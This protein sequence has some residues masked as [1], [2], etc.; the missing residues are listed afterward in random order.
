MVYHTG[1]K[2][3]LAVLIFCLVSSCFVYV[4]SAQSTTVAA[5]ASPDKL[6]VGDTLTVTVKIRDAV[7]LYGVDVTLNWNSSVLKA[8]S[9]TNS[10]GVESNSNGVL[11]KSSAYPIDVEEDAINDGQYHLLATSQGQ[12]TPSFSGSGTIVTIIFNVTGSGSANLALDNVELSTRDSTGQISLVTPETNVSTVTAT[13]P[14]FPATALVL[15][16]AVAAAAIILIAAKKIGKPQLSI[17]KNA[18]QA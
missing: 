12:S 14:E 13:I 10:L 17:A 8:V 18:N 4:A 16:L 5:E 3:V 1:G 7:D 11:H 9:A 15:A 6:K 2:A